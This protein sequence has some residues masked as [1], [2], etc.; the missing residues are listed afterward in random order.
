MIPSEWK[1]P[2][3]ITFSSN[4]IFSMD[5]YFFRPNLC[6]HFH[7][8]V[9]SSSWPH[10]SLGES[11][12][13]QAHLHLG[14]TFFYRALSIPRDLFFFW[15]ASFP[16]G[17]SLLPATSFPWP[18]LL[19]TWNHLLYKPIFPPKPHLSSTSFL[20]RGIVFYLNAPF[21]QP[22]PSP[23]TH[24]YLSPSFP[25]PHPLPKDSFFSLNHVFSST[26]FPPMEPSFPRTFIWVN[27]LLGATIFLMEPFPK[28]HL[29][30]T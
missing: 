17:M 22:L 6:T 16:Q 30:A 20:P 11:F 15:V 27:H 19:S 9:T 1:C 4:P 12:L 29:H 26:P 14:A 25:K 7:L 28:N 10:P 18:H 8:T 21:P 2:T 23:R 13:P 3:K 24:L 5:P